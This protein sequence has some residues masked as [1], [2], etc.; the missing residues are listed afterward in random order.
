MDEPV[1]SVMVCARRVLARGLCGAHYARWRSTGDAG[2]TAVRALQDR[3]GQCSVEGCDRVRKVAGYC[4]AHYWRIRT[5]GDPG[6]AEIARARAALCSV[7]GC[8]RSTVGRGLCRMHYERQRKGREVGSAAPLKRAAGQGSISNG[9]HV[10]TVSPGCSRLAHRVVMENLLGRPLAKGETV[11]HVNGDRSDNTTDG[12]LDE[13]Y[14]S[15][16]LEL[17]SSWQPAG[18]RVSDKITYAEDLLRRYAPHVLAA[19][20]KEA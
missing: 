7:V 2:D 16:N 4:G 1:C 18:Q 8:D 20:H 13:R 12:P 3:D 5:H 14:R 6:P 11:H 9:Y 17:W 15:G 19:P 10:V